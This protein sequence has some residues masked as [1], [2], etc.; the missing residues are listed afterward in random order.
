[1][2]S[3][4]RVGVRQTG[5]HDA[6]GCIDPPSVGRGGEGRSDPDDPVL[7]EEDIGSHER[8]WMACED[9]TAG[10]EERDGALRLYF[11]CGRRSFV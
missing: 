11:F 5:Q 10:E 9:L 4:V 2:A 7:L 3:R 6:S 8:G 1:M